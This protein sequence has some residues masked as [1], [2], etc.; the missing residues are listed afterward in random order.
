MAPVAF[1]GGQLRGFLAAFIRACSAM[2]D[3]LEPLARAEHVVAQDARGLGLRDRAFEPLGREIIL[4]AHVDEGV[5]GL[6]GIACEQDALQQL[7]GV[8]LHDEAVLEGARLGFVCVHHEVA[9]VDARGDEAPFDACGEA[10]AAA[11]A[12]VGCLHDVDDAGRKKED[13][14]RKIFLLPFFF[15]LF[16]RGAHHCARGLVAAGGEVGREAVRVGFVDVGEEEVGVGAAAVAEWASWPA[17]V[18]IEAVAGCEKGQRFGDLFGRF[19]LFEVADAAGL[20]FGGHEH[21][22]GGAGAEALHVAERELAV[23][24]GL[25]EGDAQLFFQAAGELARA[26]QHAGNVIAHLDGDVARLAVDVVHV[27]EAGELADLGRVEAEQRA[28][29]GERGGGEPAVFGL[30]DI[31]R[32]PQR[33]AGDGIAGLQGP[34]FG[35]GFVGQHSGLHVHRS[36]SPRTMSIVP[37]LM[38]RSAM[39]RPWDMVFSACRLWNEGVR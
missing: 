32:G 30:R 14:R 18:A 8:I 28:D 39:S 25:A 21:G 36:T 6:D 17:L 20:L 23:G 1:E 3:D 31:E 37:M 4:A 26:A 9:R 24:G 38:M 11:A 10:G 19:E 35:Y 34:D 15:F 33:G 2:D 12:D 22:R 16:A 7:V 27:V 29:L 5:L 13:G